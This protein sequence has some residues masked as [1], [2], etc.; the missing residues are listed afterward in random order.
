MI[1]VLIITF[2]VV[3]VAVANGTDSKL[4]PPVISE[5]PDYFSK[6]SD[7]NQC[8]SNIYTGIQFDPSGTSFINQANDGTGPSS[9]LCEKK[10]WAIENSLNWDGL[11]NNP[12]ICY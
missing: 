8:E 7:T 11:T 10:K 5:C 3:G 6:N 9:A 12:D 2:T 4:F 1:I